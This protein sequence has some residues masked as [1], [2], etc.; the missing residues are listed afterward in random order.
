M[1][2]GSI[3]NLLKI[4]VGSITGDKNG[5]QPEDGAPAETGASAEIGSTESGDVASGENETT[6]SSGNSP[7]LTNGSENGQRKSDLSRALDNHVDKLDS[8]LEKAENAHYS[9]AHQN[10]QMKKFLQ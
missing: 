5:D 6:K 7:P 3:T 1:R 4:K 2:C 10:K 9:M 8:M